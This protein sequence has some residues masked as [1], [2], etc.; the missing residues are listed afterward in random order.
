MHAEG[1]ELGLKDASSLKSEV[2]DPRSH[3]EHHQV[4]GVLYLAQSKE[5]STGNRQC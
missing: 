5:F 3:K 4:E 1:G 2:D